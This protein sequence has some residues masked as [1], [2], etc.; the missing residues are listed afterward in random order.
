MK[1]RASILITLLVLFFFGTGTVKEQTD[2]ILVYYTNGTHDSYTISELVKIAHDTNNLSVYTNLLGESEPWQTNKISEI[3]KVVFRFANDEYINVNPDEINLADTKATTATKILYGYLKYYYGKKLI[4]AGMAN[5]AWNTKGAE[6]VDSITG[7]YPAI[8]YF[9]FIHIPFDGSWINYSDISPVTNWA[10]KGG[11]VALGWHFNVPANE[12]DYNT[13]NYD[14]LTCS[15]SKTTWNMTDIYTEGTWE[16]KWFYDQMDKVCNILL[17]LQDAGIVALWRPFHEASGNVYNTQ[18]WPYVSWFWWGNG[19]TSDTTPALKAVAYKKLWNTM[20]DY[21]QNK[22][23]H[24]LIWVWVGTSKMKN[25]DADTPYYPGDDKV[26]IVA[27]DCYGSSADE[28]ASQFNGLTALYPSKMISMAECGND[29][30]DTGSSSIINTKMAKISEAWAAGAKFSY[31]MPWYD[32]YF[33]NGKQTDSSFFPA[34]YW[35][36]AMNMTN[37]VN[38]NN[39]TKK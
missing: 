23:I 16:N 25:V 22:G 15:P 14:G 5:V 34:E 8:S 6:H 39:W 7:A 9:D 31:F 17:K 27:C 19:G 37:I 26:D 35:K 38:M 11:A 10:A 13:K 21:F 2:S 30:S 29:I 12:N 33:E 20:F 18:G 28:L 24:N 1:K 4:T 3:Q 36:D 32:Y